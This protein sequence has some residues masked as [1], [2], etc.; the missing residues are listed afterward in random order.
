[1]Y[2]GQTGRDFRTRF[3]EHTW[4]IQLNQMKLKD[5]R[6]TDYNHKHGTTENTTDTIRISQKGKPR[7]T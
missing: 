6:H 1:M 7:H 2:T 3:T 4:D 5:A